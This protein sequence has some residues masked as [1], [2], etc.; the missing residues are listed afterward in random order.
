MMGSSADDLLIDDEE[1][2]FLD[3]NDPEDAIRVC[4]SDCGGDCGTLAPNLS[5]SFQRLL[6]KLSPRKSGSFI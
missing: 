4:K 1:D 3:P 6:N 5:C 2:D